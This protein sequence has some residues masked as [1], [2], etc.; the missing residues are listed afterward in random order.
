[1]HGF[2]QGCTL[3]QELC[4]SNIYDLI[5]VQDTWLVPTNMHKILNFND[6]YVGFG[7]SAMEQTVEK[8]LLRGRP[9]GGTAILVKENLVKLCREINTFDR[10]VIVTIGD[11]LL[12]NVYLPCY[13]GSESNIN[14]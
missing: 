3:L 10:V 8:G 7:I 9:G 5:F 1:M 14:V 6:N 4:N 11:V 2:N 12:I 13:D